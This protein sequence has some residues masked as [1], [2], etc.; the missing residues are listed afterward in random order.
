MTLWV[1][2]RDQSVAMTLADYR[3]KKVA[4]GKTAEDAGW[5]VDYVLDDTTDE[6]LDEV[7][8]KRTTRAAD[9]SEDDAA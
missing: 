8:P 3:S 1:Y 4:D 2:F 6:R 5:A 9:K 7:P